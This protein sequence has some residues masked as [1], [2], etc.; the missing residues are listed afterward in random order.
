MGNPMDNERDARIARARPWV[1]ITASG[2]GIYAWRGEVQGFEVAQE[3]R[4]EGLQNGAPYRPPVSLGRCRTT[5]Q[6]I[7]S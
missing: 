5:M 3:S 2:F 4:V 1:Y 7:S 6:M